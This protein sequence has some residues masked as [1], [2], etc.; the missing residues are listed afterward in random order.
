[1]EEELFKYIFYFETGAISEFD[2]VQWAMNQKAVGNSS[3]PINRLAAQEKTEPQLIK[4]L[5]QESIEIMGLEYPSPAVI[6]SYR[7]RLISENMINGT[8]S[9]VKGCLLLSRIGAKHGWS[10]MMTVF[11]H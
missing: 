5:F 3:S 2:I 1:M 7:A 11:Q 4:L 6:D 9:L 8:I 10:E